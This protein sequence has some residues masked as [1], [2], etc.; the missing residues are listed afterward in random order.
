MVNEQNLQYCDYATRSSVFSSESDRRSEI[1]CPK[2]YKENEVQMDVA[3][4][5][6]IPLLCLETKSRGQ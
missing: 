3:N 5:Q 6:G 2:S 1:C 4:S